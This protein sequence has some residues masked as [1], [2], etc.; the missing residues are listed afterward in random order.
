VL[1]LSIFELI[2]F[3][4]IFASRVDILFVAATV[5]ESNRL[6]HSLGGKAWNCGPLR[7]VGD[8][9]RSLL[10]TGVG[11]VNTARSLGIALELLKPKKV[12]N[13]GIAGSFPGGP[14][15]GEVVE[16]VQEAFSELG[17][18]SP[19]GF[20]PFQ[21]LGFALFEKDGTAYS[22]NLNNPS[23]S[24]MILRKVAGITVN[25][26]HGDLSGIHKVVAR[27]S[28]EVETM[29]GAAV[30][31][32]CIQADVPFVCLR[33]ISNVVEPRNRESW[34]IPQAISAVEGYVLQQFFGQ[35]T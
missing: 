17:A 6:A 27:W 32:C 25:T 4:H 10:V 12:V 19:N 26:V 1:F 7:L 16:V 30:F 14:M 31:Q 34:K 13:L 18:D 11:M 2:S 8:E 21:E 20:I 5:P 9:S 22:T 3:V 29:E 15:V 23:P 33:A 28:P 24:D 35:R